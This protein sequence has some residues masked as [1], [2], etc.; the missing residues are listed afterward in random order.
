MLKLRNLRFPLGIALLAL[1]LVC[2]ITPAAFAQVAT[3]VFTGTVSDQSGAV[4]PGATVTAIK[5]ATNVEVKARSN[6]EGLYTVTNLLPGYYTLKAEAK[7]FRILLDQHIELT[8]GYTQ[9]VDLKLEVGSVTQ[10]VT[11]EGQ[12][13]LVNTEEGHLSAL[14]SGQEATNLPLNGRN[15]YQLMQLVPGAV[16]STNVDTESNEGGIQTNING[17]R[18]NFNGFLLDGVPNKGLSGGSDAQPAPDFIQEFRIMTNNFSAEYGSSAGSMTDVSIKSGSNQF[19]GDGW[20]FFRNDKLNARNFFSGPTV[21]EWRQNQFGGTLGG[22]VKKNKLFFFAG[23]EGERFRTQSPALYTFETP[24]FRNAVESTLPNSTAALLYKDFPGVTNPTYGFQTLTDMMSSQAALE[25]DPVGS[26]NPY[27]PGA[28][29]L[30]PAMAYTDPCFQNQWNLYGTPTPGGP[31]FGNAQT[32]ANKMASLIGVTPQEQAQ[33]AANIAAVPGCAGMVAP[34]AQAGAIAPD[35]NVLGFANGTTPTRTAGQF[36][37]GDQLVARVDYQSDANRI[38][39]RLYYLIYKDPN[40]VTGPYT[41][42]GFSIPT[43][44]SYPGFGFGFVHNFSGTTIN[45]FHAGYIR[46]QTSFIPN[47]AQFGV[48]NVEFDDGVQQFGAYGGYPQFFDENVFD[49]RD[50]V[51][52]VK[53][54]H[55][56]KVGF[57]GRRNYENSEFDIG[58]PSYGFFDPLFFA[59]D[60]PYYETGGVNP[61]FSGGGS[62]HLDT[63]IR[64]WRNSEIAAFIQDDWKVK[65]NLTFNLGVRWDFFT[66]H[67]E[68]YGKATKFVNYY[69]LAS[70]NCEAFV[71]STCVFPT[72]D[73]NSPNGGFTGASSLFPDRYTNFEPRI[74][75]AWDPKG[76]GKTSIRGG[77]AI[78]YEESFYNALSNS[79]WNL[80]YYSFNEAGAVIGQPG[81]IVYGPTNSDGT[82][83]TA[84]APTYTGSPTQAGALGNGPAA[85]GFKGNLMG[86]FP[87][88]P[89]LAALTG[90]PSPDYTLPYYE[91]AFF[92]IQHEIARNTTLEVDYVGTWGRHLFWAED[93]NRVVGGKENN[94]G[95]LNPCTG[96]MVPNTP[97]LNPCFGKLRTW[98]TSVNSSYDALQIQLNHRAA[99]GVSFTANYTYSHTLDYRSTWHSGSSGGAATDF[100]GAVVAGS[101]YGE[102][103]YSMDPNAVFLEY[104]NSLFDVPHRFVGGAIWELPWMKAQHGLAGHLLGG[105]TTNAFVTLQGGFPFTV[106]AQQDFNGTGIRS[107]RPD[108]PSF[109]VSK[110]FSDS[111][112]E[113]GSAG[114]SAGGLSVMQLIGPANPSATC[115]TAATTGCLGVF[116]RPTPGVDG[117]LGRN[118]FRG[119]GIADTDFSLFKKIPLGAAETR[120]FEFRAEFFNLFNRTNLYT[121]VS[122]LSSGEFGLSTA[123]L[124]PRLIQFGL[125]LYF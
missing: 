107:Q 69:N 124:D 85:S 41:P 50:M 48:P 29:L 2:L 52:I 22:P 108:T 100:G 38:F 7:G 34:V 71:G 61:A 36:Y 97:L 68:K 54:K 16:N 6:A 89:N 79:R 24:E 67:T 9:R 3:G 113:Q 84:V 110:S 101:A 26:S 74:G 102:G 104:G 121:P 25:G 63:N 75:F 10:T 19:H 70:V 1:G 27:A 81:Y 20:E 51:A 90:I 78:Q 8:V 43:T 14:V 116:P 95:E 92:G 5:E 56:L 57:E 82:P 42:R 86:W 12:A 11:V 13:P 23:Y 73:T 106:G 35:T 112:Y 119:P 59:A 17:T 91:N 31:L 99:Q 21:P 125:K 94:V 47:P 15:I 87:G 114:P 65:K 40:G 28:Y 18:A 83:A 53:G 49:L 30:D 66:P 123:A 60:Q 62:P 37:N 80:P 111:D 103:G 76:S 55:S 45:E 64:A 33:I 117:N 120:Y 105:W 96:Q 88:N 122:N 4:I 115:G 58:R 44:T 72:G 39:G 118:T 109:G 32:L 98:D 46:N 93:P 77:Y